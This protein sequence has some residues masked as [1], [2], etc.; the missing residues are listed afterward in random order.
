MY[1]RLVALCEKYNIGYGELRQMHK[2]YRQPLFK[3]WT[4]GQIDALQMVFSPM[5]EAQNLDVV[6][7]E[8]L[9][10]FFVVKTRKLAM[11]SVLGF[12]GVDKAAA[13]VM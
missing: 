4:N 6:E 11:V 8:E 5:R 13:K 9:Q 7:D 3:Y 10:V 2:G 12:L 1:E